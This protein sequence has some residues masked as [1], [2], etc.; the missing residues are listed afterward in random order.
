MWATMITVL[1]LAAHLSRKVWCGPSAVIGR[2][3]RTSRGRSGGNRQIPSSLHSP[4]S[5]RNQHRFPRPFGEPLA[6]LDDL[7][8]HLVVALERLFRI[9]PERLYMNKSVLNCTMLAIKVTGTP[10]VEPRDTFVR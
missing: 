3:W 2:I 10:M 1:A 6:A 7:H 5:N 9:G 8:R 4:H